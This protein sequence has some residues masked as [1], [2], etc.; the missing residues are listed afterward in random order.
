MKNVKNDKRKKPIYRKKIC[1]FC[2][3]NTMSIDYKKPDILR[4]FVTERG[5][6]MSR[7]ITGNC[8]LHQ[9][10]LTRAIKRARNV[11]LMPYTTMLN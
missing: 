3:D 1:K 4:G 8:A 6:I 9:R 10:S 7:R 11:S 5:K 2:T